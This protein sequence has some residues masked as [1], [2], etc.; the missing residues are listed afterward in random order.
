MPQNF[1]AL[2]VEHTRSNH[3]TIKKSAALVV[4]GAVALVCCECAYTG[5]APLSPL[6]AGM[7]VAGGGG[8]YLLGTAIRKL[9]SDEKTLSS[10]TR[11]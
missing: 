11:L 2:M 10:E 7:F 5:T 6:V 1:T 8:A 4:I 9:S 3:G